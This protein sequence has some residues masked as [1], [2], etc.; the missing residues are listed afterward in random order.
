MF[1]GRNVLALL[2]WFNSRCHSLS[3]SPSYPPPLTH[4]GTPLPAPTKEPGNTDPGS[5]DGDSNNDG[6]PPSNNDKDAAITTKLS[7]SLAVLLLTV[8]LLL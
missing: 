5:N 4:T 1:Y 2:A 7:L 8:N 6:D 3:L